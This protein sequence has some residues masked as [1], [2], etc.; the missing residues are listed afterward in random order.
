AYDRYEDRT[1][2]VASEYQWAAAD[3]VDVVAGIS[4]DWRDSLEGMKHEKN[5]SVTHYDDN[6][7]S[8]FNWQMMTK[9][10][11]ENADTLALSYSDRT[12]FPTL[13]ERYTTSKPAYN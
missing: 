9:Y 3:N 13:K 2:S 4:Y 1:W 6:N 11:F 7:Q 5:G 8:A 10:H 12:R